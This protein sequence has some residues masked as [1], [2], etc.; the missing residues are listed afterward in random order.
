MQCSFV[1]NK[2]ISSSL[3]FD[4]VK[5]I[6]NQRER[7]REENIDKETESKWLLLLV[8]SEALE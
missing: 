4:A 1:V 6:F 2:P 5:T 7:E 3:L 8:S